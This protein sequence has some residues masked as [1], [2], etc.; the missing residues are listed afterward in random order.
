MLLD[1]NAQFDAGSVNAQLKYLIKP[2]TAEEILCTVRAL[3]DSQGEKKK[4]LVVDDDD[5]LRRMLAAVLESAGYEVTQAS[6]GREV[7]S[8]ACTLEMDVILTEIVMHEVEGLQLI[9][10]LLAREPQLK[11]VAMSGTER[12]E[13]YLAVARS[14]GAKAILR[15]PLHTEELLHLLKA[16]VATTAS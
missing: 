12:A 9:R 10:E 15:K 4:V 7:L 11:I 16:L 8:N 2:F 6:N 14:L 13:T 5:S 1:A 3:L